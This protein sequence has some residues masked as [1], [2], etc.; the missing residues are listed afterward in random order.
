MNQAFD[1]FRKLLDTSDWPPR[2]HCGKWTEFHGWLYIISDLLI[3]SA[4]FAIPLIILKFVSR[5]SKARFVRAYFLFA[6]FILA[7]GSTHLLDAITFWY[8]AYRLNALVRLITGVVSWATVFYMIRIMPEAMTLK[9]N[10]E[11]EKEVQERRK[12]ESELR[13]ANQQLE[14]AQAIANMGNWQWDIASDKVTWSVKLYEIFGQEK[15][16]EINFESYLQ[17]IHPDDR[18]RVSNLVKEALRTTHFPSFYHRIQQDTGPEKIIL[19][20]GEVLVNEAGRVIGMVGTAQDVTDQQKAQQDLIEKTQALE[21]TNTEL[22]RFAYVASHDLQE[23]L[24]KILTFASLLQKE[25]FGTFDERSALYIQ[26]IVQSTGRMQH[27]IEDILQFSSIKDKKQGFIPLDLNAVLQQVLSDM[28]VMIEQSGAEITWKD[29]PKVEGNPSQLGQLLQ[30]L[31]TNA[32][33]FVKPGEAP[34]I[35]IFCEQ[36]N[37]AALEQDPSFRAYLSV[38]QVSEPLWQQIDFV[39]VHVRDH[40]IGFDMAYYDKVFEIFQRL[41]PGH[42]YGGTGIGLAICKRI[43]E[44]H[45]GFISA[46]SKEG[47]GATFSFLLPVSQRHF[48]LAGL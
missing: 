29:L 33:K 7:C 48:S 46:Q 15:G 20:K 19:A 34:R 37:A 31:L 6:A 43:I 27:L 10:E 17:Y 26:K 40:G 4:Y 39:L 12:V 2:W 3:W 9:S 28:E 21:V 23:P 8:P 30:N 1:F 42:E 41:H 25:S 32:I 5:R 36:L 35:E 16:T 13:F 38:L 11:L 47:Q 44:N 14:T 18:D 24:R 22:Q 45:H